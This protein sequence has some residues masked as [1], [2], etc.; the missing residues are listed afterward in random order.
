MIHCLMLTYLLFRMMILSLFLAESARISTVFVLKTVC[1]VQCCTVH[2]Y[3]RVRWTA[4][5][6]FKFYV[7]LDFVVLHFIVIISQHN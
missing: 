2:H 7:N 6:H 3:S 5:I 4:C 1:K